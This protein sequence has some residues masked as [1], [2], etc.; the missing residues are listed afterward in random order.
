[1]PT[2]QEALLALVAAID[3]KHNFTPAPQ[4]RPAKPKKPKV[5]APK[6]PRRVPIETFAVARQIPAY[7]EMGAHSES[8]EPPQH[9]EV[10]PERHFGGPLYSKPAPYYPFIIHRTR[11]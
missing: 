6:Q 2:L 3:A 8:R 11:K 4:L 1:M 10:F 9:D 5:Q 7:G